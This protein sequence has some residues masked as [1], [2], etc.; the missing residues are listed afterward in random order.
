[1]VIPVPFWVTYKDVV[2]YAGDNWLRTGPVKIFSDGALGSRTCHMNHPFTGEH[3]NHGMAVTDLDE[4]LS[5]VRLANSA[6]IAVATHAIGDRANQLVLDAY[7]TTHGEGLTGQRN[8]IEHVQHLRPEDVTRM[9][10]LGVV[11]SMQPTHCTSDIS[12]VDS[13][14]AGQDLASYA[15]RSMLNAGVPLAFGS[16]APVEDPNPFLALYAAMTRSRADGTPAGG[17][18]PEQRLTAAEAFTAH[19]LGSAY[20]SGDE[21]R[22]G[23]LA[24]GRLADFVAVDVDP[25]T[26]SP[27]AVRRTTV[28]TT[29]VGGEI[30][31][32]RD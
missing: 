18:Q 29:V 8:R 30:R 28:L 3:G 1:M 9:A 20:A 22:K 13:L 25:F 2:N 11:A 14:L 17:W 7:E 19:T 5:L 16:D 26:D 23:I 12:L 10:R 21:Q 4:I 15:W 6:G 31:W 27:D 24:P 32:Q